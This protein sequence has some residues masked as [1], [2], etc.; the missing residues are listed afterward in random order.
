M[1]TPHTADLNTALAD[2]LIADPRPFLDALDSVTD[3]AV[4]R[5]QLREAIDYMLRGYGLT[6]D[7]VGRAVAD[8]EA[9]RQAPRDELAERIAVHLCAGLVPQME[10]HNHRTFLGALE[11]IKRQREER[12]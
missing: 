6:H 1:S 10:Q 5:G 9:W 12:S 3:F 4:F 2:D 11:L 7:H 8:N